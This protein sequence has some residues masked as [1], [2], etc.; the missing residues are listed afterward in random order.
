MDLRNKSKT[1]KSKNPR[2][3]QKRRQSSLKLHQRVGVTSIST[4]MTYGYQR[5][6]TT[7]ALVKKLATRQ[8]AMEKKM[9]NVKPKTESDTPS[10]SNEPQ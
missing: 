10:L 7:K 9:F 3:K 1:L 6:S 8:L 2:K 4:S 5:W